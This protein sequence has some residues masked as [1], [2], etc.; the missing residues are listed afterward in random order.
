MFFPMLTQL[1]LYLFKSIFE[2]KT[3]MEGRIPIDGD[4]K[5]EA[6]TLTQERGPRIKCPQEIPNMFKDEY[7]LLRAEY[8]LFFE[9]FVKIQE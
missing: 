2:A 5:R 6:G 9:G 3:R 1:S 7:T 4:E 8:V